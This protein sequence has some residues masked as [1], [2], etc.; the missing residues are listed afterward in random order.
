MTL[1]NTNQKIIIKLELSFKVSCIFKY[2]FR[3]MILNSIPIIIYVELIKCHNTH[4]ARK[5]K[6]CRILKLEQFGTH[7]GKNQ[8]LKV[9]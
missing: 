5:D 3:R 6:K 4:K 2:K 7:L 8:F 9:F 1:N